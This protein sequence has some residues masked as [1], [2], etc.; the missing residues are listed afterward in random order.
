MWSQLSVDARM[1][2]VESHGMTARATIYSPSFGVLQLPIA[3]GQVDQDATSQVRR[4]AS[5][6]AD[7]TYWPRSPQDLLA[8]YGSEAL[9]EYGVVLR[10]GNIEWV[11]CGRLSL[12]ET[13]RKRPLSGSADIECKLVDR[14]ARVADDRLDAPAQT[15]A[16][17]TT[18]AEIT[19]LIQAT[20]TASVTVTDFTG[21]TQVAP[22]MEIARERWQ[23]VEKLADAIGAEVFFDRYGQGVIR[24]QPTLTDAAVWQIQT[25]EFG[26]ILSATDRLTREGVYNRVV[27][28]GAGTATAT[29]SDTD[30]ASPTYYGGP[31]GKKSRY[32]S[33]QLL[34]TNPQCTT[35][36]TA[37]LERARGTGVQVEHETLV[38]PALDPGDVITSV[39]TDGVRRTHIL[40]KVPIPLTP[41]GTQALGTRS[42]DLP[43]ESEAG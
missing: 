28:I 19:R 5:I 35:T 2:L 41:G 33:S 21:S 30:P 16:G 8:P 27:V 22:T 1:A 11:P 9:V 12:D 15:V 25:G 14:S 36:A 40:D 7:P 20:L 29:V 32:Y 6:L 31:F 39:D 3:G 37:L 34:T 42:N 10:S 24:A 23:A 4:T 43:P 38:N 13:Q 18:V 17:A 26:N